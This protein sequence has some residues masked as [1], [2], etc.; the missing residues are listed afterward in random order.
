MVQ[1]IW[2]LGGSGIVSVLIIA[3]IFLF[4]FGVNKEASNTAIWSG[5]TIG[6]VLGVLGII[7]VLKR[8]F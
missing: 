4:A 6:I 1:K 5:V 2:A 3:G 8:M 7:G